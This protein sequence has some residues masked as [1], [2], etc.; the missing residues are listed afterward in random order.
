MNVIPSATFSVEARKRLANLILSGATDE[1]RAKIEKEIEAL[2][3]PP[4]QQERDA[5][6]AEAAIAKAAAMRQP[7]VVPMKDVS[8]PTKK[9]PT[10]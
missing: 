4:T 2:P 3:P 1:E 9:E 10:K 7:G 6:A 5:A 8:P